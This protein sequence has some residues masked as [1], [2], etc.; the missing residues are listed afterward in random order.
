[1]LAKLAC[2]VSDLLHIP[3]EAVTIYDPVV[4]TF[5]TGPET[6]P[7]G[8]VQEYVVPEV[9]FLDGVTPLNEHVGGVTAVYTNMFALL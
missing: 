3:A 6:V 5:T 7:I 8:L 4:L 1:L 9:A 2:I